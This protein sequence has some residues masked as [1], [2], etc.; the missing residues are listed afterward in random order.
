MLHPSVPRVLVVGSLNMD[1]VVEATRLPHTGETVLG[2]RAHYLSGG[3][4]ANQAVAAARLGAE[5]AMI[6]AVGKD[7]FGMELKRAMELAGIAVDTIATV[8]EIH[9]GM[10]SITLSEGDNRIIVVPGA[11]SFCSPAD[12]DRHE[13]CFASADIILLQL[14][15]PLE[16]VAYA[17]RM[18]KRHGK[19]V[20]LNPAPAQSL[21][22][23]FM[24]LIDYVTPNRSE[25]ALLAG[26]PE[27]DEGD[28]NAEALVA[29]MRKLQTQGAGS[30]V[31]TLGA[32]GAIALGAGGELIQVPGIP[33]EV[34][35]TTGAGDCFNGALACALVRG[36]T[37]EEAIQFAVVASALSV[38][39]LGAQ[40]GMP[41]LEEVAACHHPR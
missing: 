7:A 35:D 33:M 3:K 29:A 34:V 36:G 10:A 39:K 23:G 26:M 19:P 28:C 16:T 18:A 1:V 5:T 2:Q 31:V 40:S 37:L 9:T 41:T 17:A 20:V 25:L 38:T 15:I 12:I 8:E 4:G 14:E 6:G 24:S 22:A 13:A 11:N 30:V 27:L 32:A 21:S